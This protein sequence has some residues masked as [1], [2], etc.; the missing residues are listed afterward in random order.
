[1]ADKVKTD[2]LDQWHDYGVYTPARLI[3]L[4]GGIDSDKATEF[5][6][7]IRLL[8]HVSDREIKILINSDGGEVRA[9]MDIVDAIKECQSK[10]ITHVV[11]V[12]ESMAAIIVQAGDERLISPSASIMIHV[13]DEGYDPTHP[14]NLEAWVKETKR[15][16]KL[17]DNLLYQQIKKKKPRFAK[18][19]FEDLITFDTIYTAKEAIDMGLV[20]K[21]VEHK[22]L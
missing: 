11:G 12:A 15:L 9:G 5:I 6:K 22:S 18:K 10:V 20:D 19:A 4:S 7:N 17:A 14:K 21:I 13:G 8:D 3:D 16:G 1:M 2:E